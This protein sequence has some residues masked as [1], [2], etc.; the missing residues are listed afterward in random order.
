MESPIYVSLSRQ[1]ALRRQMDV[2]ANNIANAN[3]TGFKRQGMLFNEYLERPS[4]HERV[5]FVQDRAVVRDTRAGQTV[6]TNNTLD[7]A[8]TGPGYFTV[9]TAS[10]RRYTRA[11]DF[12]LNDRREIVDK[13]GLP[14]LDDRGQSMVVP[15]GAREIRVTADGTLSTEQGQV[16]KFNLV[17]FPNEQLMT[18]VG[19]GLYVSDEQPTSAPEETKVQQGMLEQS[20]VNTIVETTSMI[21]ILRQYQ[22]NQNLITAESDRIRNAIKRLAKPLA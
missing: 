8:L 4:L 18:E 11:G 1:N 19:G 17:T 9:D 6:Q 12:K 7:F 2:I 22:T 15:N 5:S 16:G 21:D 14:V 20:N 10:G 3:T 13:N